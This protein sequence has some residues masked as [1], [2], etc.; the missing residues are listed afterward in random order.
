MENF[1]RQRMIKDIKKTDNIIQVLGNVKE[2]TGK[3]LLLD[4]TTGEIIVEVN[5]LDLKVKIGDLINVVGELKLSTGGETKICAEIV[6]DR[7]GTHFE[8][9]KKLYHAKNELLKD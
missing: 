8:Y 3:N 4:D 1:S 5:D 7:K 6:Q 9:Y 2:I